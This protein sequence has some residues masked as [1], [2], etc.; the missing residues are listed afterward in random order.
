MCAWCKFTYWYTWMHGWGACANCTNSWCHQRLTPAAFLT[1]SPPLPPTPTPI[2]APCVLRHSLLWTHSSWIQP[3]W[4]ASLLQGSPVSAPQVLGFQVCAIIYSQH[5]LSMWVPDLWPLTSDPWPTLAWQVLYP[6]SH[7]SSPYFP[8][9]WK[10]VASC[11]LFM[12]QVCQDS[13]IT[14]T[15]N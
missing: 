13:G 2:P 9:K 5:L 12:R 6:L 10:A 1:C 3:V 15:V 7:L 11:S 4:L 14:Y 8:I